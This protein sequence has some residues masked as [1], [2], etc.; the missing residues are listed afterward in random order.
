MMIKKMLCVL[1]AALGMIFVACGSAGGG[2]AGSPEGTPDD[3]VPMAV[4]SDFDL[5]TGWADLLNSIAAEGKYVALDLSAC[6]ASGEFDPGTANTGEQYI[7]SLVLPGGI[8][9]IKDGTSANPT[10][11]H[12]TA[13]TR[14]TGA[15]VTDIGEWAF[16]YRALTAADFPA[17]TDIG[18][19]AFWY[20]YRLKTADFPAAETIGNQAF[21][22]CSGLET[23]R[24]PAAKHI[25]S[26]AFQNCTTLTAVSLPASL[27]TIGDS[28]YNPGSPFIGCTRLT[29]ITVD[30]ANAAYKHSGDRRML[31]SKDGATLIAYPT[32]AGAVVT[33]DSITGIAA[34]A[35]TGCTALTSVSLPNVTEIRAA[36]QGCTALTSADLPAV[37]SIGGFAFSGCTALTTVHLPSVTRIIGRSFIG[38][39]GTAL[40]VTLGSTVPTLEENTFD[41]VDTAK[42][43][44]VKVPSGAAAWSGIVSGS[45]YNETGS[46]TN[47]WGNAFRG[48]GWNGTG[49]LTGTVNANIIITIEE[50]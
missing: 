28:P 17:A 6:P 24:L 1:L 11:E 4:G 49:Y 32:A 25:Y 3:P 19:Q 2:P 44:T 22:G 9:S 27:T 12:F 26:S 36:F 38:T 46:Y 29:S 39:G 41:G 18:N 37:T 33:P 40:T 34:Y 31:L 35:F 16:A 5:S 15:G 7:V 30:G 42:T 45:P 13:L 14:V 23:V 8:T 48:M 10:F 21:T 20:C 50:Q 43:V 47:N